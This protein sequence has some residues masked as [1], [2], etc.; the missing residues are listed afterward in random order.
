MQGVAPE[1]RE[2]GFYDA[3]QPPSPFPERN[4]IPLLP[5][6]L[7]AS[8]LMS[9]TTDEMGPTCLVPGSH[10]TRHMPPP[11]VHSG[12]AACSTPGCPGCFHCATAPAQ[13]RVLPG[14]VRFTGR[15]GDIL[16]NDVSIWHTSGPNTTD[17][18]RKLCWILWGPQGGE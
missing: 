12:S 16:L 11:W 9:D 13:P 15:A 5:F 14:M 1:I 4:G 7:R 18:T 10:G 17:E 6:M 8:I 3:P 2:P